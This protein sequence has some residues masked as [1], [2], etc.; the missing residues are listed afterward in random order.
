MNRVSLEKNNIQ[1]EQKKIVLLLNV[2][3]ILFYFFYNENIIEL[4]H[5]FFNQ[6]TLLN[7]EIYL[8]QTLLYKLL[9]QH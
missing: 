5:F 8:I 9:C 1:Q 3:S 2:C 6:A 4:S 7:A